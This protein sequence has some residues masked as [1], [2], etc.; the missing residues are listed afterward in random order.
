MENW[1]E[2]T[3]NAGRILESSK[4]SITFQGLEG[5][6]EITHLASSCGCTQPEF[7]KETRK[8]SV[9]YSAGKVS[10]H[11]RMSPKQMVAYQTITVTYQDATKE[12]LRFNV[13]V[14]NN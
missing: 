14:F 5:M 1:R 3:I 7:D 9:T 10:K 13:T 8:L 6:K 2:K 4:H 11:L 12:V